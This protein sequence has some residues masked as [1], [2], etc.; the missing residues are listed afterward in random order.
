MERKY[1]TKKDINKLL[2]E[3]GLVPYNGGDDNSV[4][5]MDTYT[6]TRKMSTQL[7]G[8]NVEWV[9]SKIPDDNHFFS[10]DVVVDWSINLNFSPQSFSF[11]PVIHRIHGKLHVE[12]YLNNNKQTMSYDFNSEKY[13]I[14][15]DKNSLT[16]NNENLTVGR[17]EINVDAKIVSVHAY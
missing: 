16:D 11:E 17:V 1:I 12:N 8:N 13:D 14:K 2:K 6:E 7:G 10:G 5:Q 3:N 9:W 15:Y 4:E